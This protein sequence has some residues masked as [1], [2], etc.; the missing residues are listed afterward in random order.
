MKIWICAFS[1]KLIISGIL[2]LTFPLKEHVGLNGVQGPYPLDRFL[3]CS[4]P[5]ALFLLLDP[6]RLSL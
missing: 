4:H 1:C 2:G 6:C 5:L 3:L